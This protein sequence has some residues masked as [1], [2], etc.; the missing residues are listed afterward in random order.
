MRFGAGYG[1]WG[2]KVSGGFK[3][4]N[5]NKSGLSF[6]MHYNYSFGVKK[7]EQNLEVQLKGPNIFGFPPQIEKLDL[8]YKLASSLNI[9]LAY[10]F[11]LNDGKTK[12]YIELSYGYKF[13]EAP[14]E[15]VNR[16]NSEFLE[17]TDRSKAAMRLMQPGGIGFAFGY[18]FGI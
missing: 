3:I 1:I 9:A 6:G 8:R 18:L 14:Y 10:N 17:L 12:F 7:A 11:R 4:Q 15:I 5:L 13:E 16:P 2:P